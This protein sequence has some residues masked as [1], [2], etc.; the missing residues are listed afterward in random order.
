MNWNRIEE[1]FESA[2]DQPA[3]KREAHLRAAAASDD[4]F[5]FALRI[6][7]AS[8]L[9]TGF[10]TSSLIKDSELAL[11]S[12]GAVVGEWRVVEAIGSGGMGDVYKV[13]R[14]TGDFQQTGALKLIR[15]SNPEIEERFSTECQIAASLNHTNIARLVDGGKTDEGQLYMVVDLASGLPIT[16]YCVKNGL[17]RSERLS[18]FS[19]LCDA[20]GYAHA[21]LVLHRDLKPSNI[22]VREDGKLILLDFGVAAFLAGDDL[23]AGAPLTLAYAA[24]EQLAGSSVSIATDVFTLGVILNEVLTGARSR[25]KA[26]ASLDK[27]LQAIINR[28]LQSEPGGRYRSVDGLKADLDRY[29]N[30]QPVAARDGGVGYRIARFFSRYRIQTVATGLVFAALTAALAFSLSANDRTRS[31][32]IQAQEASDQWEFEARTTR[33]LRRALLQVYGVTSEQGDPIAGALIDERLL[34]L[35]REAELSARQGD[36]QQAHDMY[37]IGGHFMRR[38]D[39]EK[40]VDVYQRLLGIGPDDPILEL[41]IKSALAASLDNAGRKDEALE[42]AQQVVADERMKSGERIQDYIEASRLIAS[43]SGDAEDRAQVISMMQDAI[44]EEAK[45]PISDRF[46]TRWYHNKIGLLHLQNGDYESA[47]E[48]FVEEFFHARDLGVRSLEM[49]VT[50]TNAAQAQIFVLREGEAP[51]SYLPDYLPYV[52]GDFGDDVIRHGFILS[53]MADAALLTKEWERAESVAERAMQLLSADKAHRAGRYYQSALTRIRALLALD[54]IQ[55]AEAQLGVFDDAALSSESGVA[56]VALCMHQFAQ[57]AI[58]ARKGDVASAVESH[59]QAVEAC[60]G[61][62]GQRLRAS[63]QFHSDGVS[64]LW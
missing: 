57:A 25:E 30:R 9:S 7:R 45:R 63:F 23:E 13:V 42:L 62:D 37:A 50:A 47:A 38:F 16:D 35:S 6:V 54:N 59:E 27:D 55:S 11:L 32:L 5:N 56:G 52:N 31:A 2:L 60:G 64:S 33:A 43:I 15:G 58:L 1:L 24:P 36:L 26:C 49:V 18:V 22:L 21:K 19:E 3:D 28:C 53:L 4:E 46:Y 29:L 48:A 17:K 44:A 40:A 61:G 51:L 12:A 8:E 34:E 10:R 20:V 14:D 41:Q 39:H